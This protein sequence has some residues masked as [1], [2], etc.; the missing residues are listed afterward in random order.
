MGTGT[1]GEEGEE[2]VDVAQ[3]G[4]VLHPA[5]SFLASVF[6]VVVVVS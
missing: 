6:V 1:A 3:I 2:E 4:R 5:H